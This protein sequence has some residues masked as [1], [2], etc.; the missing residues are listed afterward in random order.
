M[1]HDHCHSHNDQS[2]SCCRSHEEQEH[3]ECHDSCHDSC[4]DEENYDFTKVLLELADEVWMEVLRD[5]IK[6]QIISSNGK[7]LD[8]LAATVAEANNARWKSKMAAKKM[9]HEY[10]DKIE[11]ALAGE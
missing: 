4:H 6:E 9:C 2:G 8:K 1:S 10:K 7:H 11:Q 3:G 5:K